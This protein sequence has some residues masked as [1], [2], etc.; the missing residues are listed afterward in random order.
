M[1]TIEDLRAHVQVMRTAHGDVS[2]ASAR[3]LACE[4]RATNSM[5]ELHGSLSALGEALQAATKAQR[6]LAV[7]LALDPDKLAGDGPVVE[8]LLEGS[9]V[10]DRTGP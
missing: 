6:A 8:P 4:R 9:A 3:L 2:E 10:G 5:S 1:A 7:L